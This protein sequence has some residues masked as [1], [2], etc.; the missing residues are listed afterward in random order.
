MLSCYLARSISISIYHCGFVGKFRQN[1]ANNNNNSKNNLLIGS[2]NTD[3]INSRFK[4]IFINLCLKK[5]KLMN[6][7]AHLE[8][9]HGLPPSGEGRLQIEGWFDDVCV[10]PLQGARR[11]LGGGRG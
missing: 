1:L 10:E 7:S 4:L 3:W 2:F 11:G 8:L 6:C 5:E 9:E